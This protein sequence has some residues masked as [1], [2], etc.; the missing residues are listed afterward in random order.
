MITTDSDIDLKCLQA[1]IEKSDEGILVVDKNRVI[2]YMNSAASL[3]LGNSNHATVPGD[4]FIYTL[5]EEET[6]EICITRENGK[7]G[8]GRLRTVDIEWEGE[9]AFLVSIR[10]ITQ[11]ILIDQLKDEFIR[12]VSHELRTPLTI[13]R[14]SVA[15]VHDGITGNVNEDQ[16]KFL[17]LCI[18]NTDRLRRMVDDL[19]DISKIEAGKVR[20][21]KRKDNLLDVIKLAVDP[22]IPLVKKK[23]L[24]LKT[25]LP[26]KSMEVYVDRDRIIQ[27]INNLIGNAVK[28]TEKGLIEI[29]TQCEN[30]HVECIVSD[31][32]IGI[33]DDNIPKVFDKFE[34][35]YTGIQLEQN[36]SGLG[37]SIAKEIVQLHDGEIFAK[38]K[39]NKGSSFGFIIPKYKPGIELLEKIKRRI[40]SSNQAFVLLYYQIHNYSDIRK[41]IGQD[42]IIESQEKM[43]QMIEEQEKHIAPFMQ[44]TNEL[45][46]LI[47]K[48]L[49]EITKLNKHLI[50]MIKESFVESASDFELDFSYGMSTFPKDG[51]IAEALLDNCRNH[52]LNEKAE[53]LNKKILIVDDEIELTEATKILIEFFG[54]KNIDIANTGE[55][56]FESIQRK[57]PELIILDMKMPGM[58]GYEVIGRLKENFETKDIPIVIMSGYEV[59]TGRFHEYINKKAILTISKP[60]DEELLRKMIYYLI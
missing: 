43:I 35:F 19:L 30:E 60:V 25:I 51:Q 3:I 9:R 34:Q 5:E 48:P 40:S 45:I 15:Q 12:N 26:E 24:E 23:G 27:V 36:G 39:I 44:E 22:F 4:R 29:K 41:K 46:M 38:S 14:E 20:L 7:T 56:A 28:F 58:S 1:I 10:D 11:Q 55:G 8:V 54:Y 21:E 33:S 13:I 50:R 17:S 37:L 18:R 6:Y 16:K 42:K 2:K 52:I 49:K 59:E 31:T 57:L 32:G 47:E 53:R